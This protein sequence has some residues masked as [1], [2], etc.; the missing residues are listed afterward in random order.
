MNLRFRWTLIIHVRLHCVIF[1]RSLHGNK[2]STS[3]TNN[4]S[5]VYIFEHMD[6]LLEIRRG[7][8]EVPPR[9]RDKQRR[10]AENMMLWAMAIAD[11]HP[12]SREADTNTHTHACKVN[13]AGVA[14]LD[15]SGKAVTTCS[16]AAQAV[17]RSRGRGQPFE[18]GPP[19]PCR[20]RGR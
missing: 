6:V 20:G 8:F 13:A 4:D 9:M 3:L 5:M 1:L 16:S 2:S 12:K 7:S 15:H 11:T 10:Q 18:R 14:T 19:A 17:V